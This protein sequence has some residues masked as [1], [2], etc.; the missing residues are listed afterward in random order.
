MLLAVF[1]PLRAR[2]AEGYVG[3]RP[4]GMGEGSRAFATGDAA[5]LLNPS[6]ISLLK[7]YVIDGGYAYGRTFSENILHASIVDNTS[8]YNLGGGIYY[9]YHAIAAPPGGSS[10][11]THEGGFALSLPFGEMLAIGTTVKYVHLVNADAGAASPRLN[12]LTFDVGATLRP[13]PIL[14]LAFVGTNLHDLDNGLVPLGL[15]YGVALLPIPNVIVVADGRTTLEPDLFTGRKG[16]SIMGGAEWTWAQRMA[17]RA[18]GGY[19]A[20]TGNGYL[21]V[22]LTGLS[23]IGALDAGLRQ[24]VSQHEDAG[25]TT[26][27]QTIV[28]VNLRLFV[29][30]SQTQPPP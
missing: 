10:G 16:T 23:E 27:R 26:P 22:G 8:S 19:D 14:S 24:D 21:T 15:G 3:S 1:L 2:A 6:G 20:S 12:G 29:P 7:N 28:G 5:L 11:Y 18:G 13:A 25:V 4:L 30:A 17:L 9:T